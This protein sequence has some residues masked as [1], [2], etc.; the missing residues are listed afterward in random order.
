MG[1]GQRHRK[2]GRYDQARVRESTGRDRAGVHV[3]IQ[4][5]LE[6]FMQTSAKDTMKSVPRGV[7]EPL[8]GGRRCLEA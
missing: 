4:E 8:W 3:H 6:V 1:I 7:A 2:G 5:K